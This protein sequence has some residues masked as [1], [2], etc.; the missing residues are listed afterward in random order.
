MIIRT[1]ADSMPSGLWHQAQERGQ[2]LRNTV[3]RTP[4]P[5]WTEHRWML[6]T[7]PVTVSEGA[8]TVTMLALLI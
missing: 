5:S 2:P 3:V 6:K 4:G 1:G 8:E 7:S